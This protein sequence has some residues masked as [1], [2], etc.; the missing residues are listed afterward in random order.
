MRKSRFSDGRR[1]MMVMM[2]M[3]ANDTTLNAVWCARVLTAVVNVWCSKRRRRDARNERMIWYD[4]VG[5]FRLAVCY[6][7]GKQRGTLGDA[8]A[9]ITPPHA[10]DTIVGRTLYRTVR[11]NA[12]ISH[13]RHGQDK[14]VLSC[15]CGRCEIGITVE[16]YEFCILRFRFPRSVARVCMRHVA[17]MAVCCTDAATVSLPVWRVVRAAASV[18]KS[19]RRRCAHL[20]CRSL[21]SRS[22]SLDLPVVVV[23]PHTVIAERRSFVVWCNLRQDWSWTWRGICDFVHKT[24]ER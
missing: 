2:M 5:I 14:T 7:W 9:T 13:R 22:K 24:L 3:C 20:C 4:T 16:L 11:R 10:T 18:D 12:Y 8:G 19:G 21:H 17:S 15:P 23:P 6:S 1:L